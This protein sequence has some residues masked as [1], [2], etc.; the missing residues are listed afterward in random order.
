M[1]RHFFKALVIFTIMIILGLAGIVLVGY[2]DKGN[3]DNQHN[4]FDSF[5]VLQNK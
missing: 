3:A 5:G 4:V 2:F 1:M